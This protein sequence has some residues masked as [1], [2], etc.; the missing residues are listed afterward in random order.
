MDHFFA[1]VAPA[2]RYDQLDPDFN[3][4]LLVGSISLAF[5][6][7]YLLSVFAAQKTLA[8]QWK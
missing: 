6:G 3:R 4:G 1:R 8:E 5:V 7:T 2:K